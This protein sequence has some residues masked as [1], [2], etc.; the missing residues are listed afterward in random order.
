MSSS[1]IV[2]FVLPLTMFRSSVEFFGFFF[3]PAF[4]G[5]TFVVSVACRRLSKRDGGEGDGGQRRDGDDQVLTQGGPSN[6]D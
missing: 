2:R 3:V 4:L 1:A 5:V 6:L